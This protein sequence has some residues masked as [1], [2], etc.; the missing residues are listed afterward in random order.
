MLLCWLYRL[1]GSLRILGQGGCTICP[2]CG[3]CYSGVDVL[4]GLPYTVGIVGLSSSGYQGAQ[5][6]DNSCIE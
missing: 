6:P 4:S 2:L 5:N 1:R 3:M